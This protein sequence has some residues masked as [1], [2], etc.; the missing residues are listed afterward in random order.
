MNIGEYELV[1]EFWPHHCRAI[2]ILDAAKENSR[3]HSVSIKPVCV[4]AEVAIGQWISAVAHILASGK[5]T[6]YRS[7]V[8]ASCKGKCSLYGSKVAG[9]VSAM[10]SVPCKHS[11]FVEQSR[12]TGEIC[13][14]EIQEQ[15]PWS[16][17]HQRA[18]LQLPSLPMDKLMGMPEYASG[19]GA[20]M[21][22]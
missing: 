3:Q 17:C 8:C 21:A 7:G 2:R 10:S 6:G 14:L 11:I 1:H 5:F 4:S 20:E 9:E 22:A 18:K 16:L 12:L 13:A 19:G 15:Q